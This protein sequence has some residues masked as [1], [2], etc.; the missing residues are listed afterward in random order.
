[1]D[2]VADKLDSINKTLEKMLA[3]MDRP[4]HKIVHIVML[5]GLFVAALG[6]VNIVDT[7]LRWI[8]GG[9]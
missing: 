8:T 3:V 5:V 6:I 4:R 9:M 2:K 1:M 7:V